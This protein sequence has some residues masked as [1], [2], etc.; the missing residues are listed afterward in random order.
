MVYLTNKEFDVSGY[1]GSYAN[2]ATPAAA[3][4]SGLTY[5]SLDFPS[6]RAGYDQVLFDSSLSNQVSSA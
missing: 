4:F 6:I 1:M 2:P 3:H 5:R